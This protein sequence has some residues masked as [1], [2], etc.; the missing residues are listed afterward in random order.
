MKKFLLYLVRWQCST[1]ILVPA[2]FLFAFLGNVWAIII[3]NF[4][5]GLI[6]FWVDKWIFND[7]SRIE[8]DHYKSG[9]NKENGDYEVYFNVPIRGLSMGMFV[10]ETKH[11]YDDW[12]RMKNGGKPIRDSWEIKNIY[13]KDFENLI[14]GGAM[15]FP[16]LGGV[17]R[18]YYLGSKL[19]TPAY[20]ENEYDAPMAQTYRNTGKKLMNF[21]VDHFFN[22][23]G[24]P[25]KGLEDEFVNIL[26]NY[27]IPFFRKFKDVRSFLTHTEKYFNKRGKD[28]VRRIDKTMYVHGKTQQ[29]PAK[30][31][32]NRSNY[33]TKG[34]LPF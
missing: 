15:K 31:T 18:M 17:V 25:A 9:Y 24:K 19:E 8:Y 3:A 30:G 1:P 22:K 33:G 2:I 23:K 7:A 34:T 27:D 20:L 10:H 28:I 11:A 32:G 14:L 16:Q 21:S 4:V 29:R 26:I 13:T 12:N 6:F 5:G